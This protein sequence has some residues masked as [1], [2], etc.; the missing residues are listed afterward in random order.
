MMLITTSIPLKIQWQFFTRNITFWKADMEEIESVV[1]E[2]WYL[3]GFHRFQLPLLSPN[4]KAANRITL[5]GCFHKEVRFGGWSHWG[6]DTQV[7]AQWGLV[8]CTTKWCVPL[9]AKCKIAKK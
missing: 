2:S 3:I 9:V 7:R 8:V 1:L 5:Y 4:Q 6:L